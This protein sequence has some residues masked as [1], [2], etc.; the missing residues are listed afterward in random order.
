MWKVFLKEEKSVTFYLSLVEKQLLNSLFTR[1]SRRFS[2]L[3]DSTA[4][5][6]KCL[7][8]IL[9]P[10]STNL[11]ETIAIR[12]VLFLQTQTPVLQCSKE[13]V[14]WGSGASCSASLQEP[15]RAFAP[16]LSSPLAQPRVPGAL[17]FLSHSSQ[18]QDLPSVCTRNATL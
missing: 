1:T 17:P 9:E 10:S 14:G 3:F 4:S 8:Y 6:L 15:A 13:P 18:I 7:V 5:V 16:T 12:S 11:R 2:F